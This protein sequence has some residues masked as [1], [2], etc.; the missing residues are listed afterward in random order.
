MKKFNL[1]TAEYAVS[2][3]RGFS[4]I[5]AM[6]LWKTKFTAFKEFSK[7]VIKHPGLK[8]LGNFIED[9]WENV[10]PISMQEALGESNMEK[11]RAM[12]D[13]IG[14]VK[15]FT[16]L[17][18]TLLDKQVVHKKQ[19]RWDNNNQPYEREYDDKYELYQLDGSKLY[20]T[21]VQGQ[22][23]N[24]VFAVRCWCST[25][26]RE[27]W[28]YVPVEAALGNEHF[29]RPTPDA[30]RAIAWT[31]QVDITCPKSIARQGDIV[32]VEES[33]DSAPTSPYHLSKEQYLQL[34]FSES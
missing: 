11:R 15:L 10:E 25:T 26:G 24:P 16:G 17:Q 33:E 34:I 13:C 8:E 14:V 21:Q 4:L 19:T 28:I 3:V 32:I 31:I 29:Y 5:E 12:F 30:I 23:S 6:R 20:V 1:H 18:P 2:A 27:Y 22:E 9:K 7:E